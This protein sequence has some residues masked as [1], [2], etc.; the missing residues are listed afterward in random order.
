MSNRFPGRRLSKVRLGILVIVL[1]ALT[2]GSY[3]GL[4]SFQDASAA[5]SIPSAFS[6][7]VDVT[8]TPRFAF[9]SPSTTEAKGAVLS[10]IVSDLQKPCAPSWGAAYSLTE[11]ESA[12]DLDRR[13]ARLR[14]IGGT[15]SVSFGGLNNSELAVGCTDQ[16]KLTDAYREV[17]DRYDLRSIDLD[18]EGSA[19]ADTASIDRRAVALAALQQDRKN[20]GKSLDVWLTLPADPA[21]LTQ[22]GRDLVLRTLRSGV[23]LAGVNIMTMDFGGSKPAAQTMYQASASA[24]DAAHTQ[25]QSI[26]RE[27]GADLGSDTAWRKLGI[28]PMIGQND[29]AG[30]IFTLDDAASLNGYA[31]SKGVGRVSMW[32]LNRDRTCGSNYPDV[33]KVSDSCSGVQQGDALFSTVLGADVV[34]TTAAKA[35]AAA[36]SASPTATDDPATSPYP[37]WKE[38]ARYVAG[39]RTVWH[40]NVYE[41]KW[42]TQGDSPD[43]PVA[44]GATVPWKLIGPVLP[45]DRPSPQATIPAGTYPDWSPTMVYQRGSRIL[46]DGHAF[47]SKWWTQSNS[48]Q[49]ALDGAPDSPWMKLTPA[50]LQ[51][52]AAK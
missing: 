41:A 9:E 31:K 42:W 18:I 3:L 50:Q 1:L 30:E 39:D 5:S 28:T 38:S 4:R 2:G 21:G 29:I 32:S 36:A 46:F 44:Q 16:S 23:E 49:A 14:Q 51:T 17:V 37:V 52:P 10:F 7:Y 33:A 34:P 22:A 27:N 8:A 26:Y 24:A 13:I 25:L 40:N 35:P 45:G 47:E 43:N 12:L 19:L 20:S 48:P 6:G 11:A 15:V